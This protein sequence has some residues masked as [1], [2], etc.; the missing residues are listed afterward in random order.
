MALSIFVKNSS[1]AIISFFRK[2][3]NIL[4]RLAGSVM[5]LFCLSIQEKMA[6]LWS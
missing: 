5:D 2:F 3:A 6:P 4:F 1:S